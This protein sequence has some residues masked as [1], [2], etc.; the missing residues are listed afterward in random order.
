MLGFREIKHHFNKPTQTFGCELLEWGARR[1]VLK[2]VSDVAYRTDGLNVDFPVGTTTI[3][4]YWDDRGYVVWQMYHP[5]SHLLGYY[6]HMV[7]PVTIVRAAV[8]YRD[9]LID[10]WF[11]PDGSHRVLDEDELEQA[12]AEG[13]VSRELARR[14]HAQ[15]AEV[16][17]TWER[18]VERLPEYAPGPARPAQA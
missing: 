12:M 16:L 7:E 6:V 2:Y 1:V 11:W 15:K 4:S 10:I 3:A 17:M 14:I 13:K 9:A 5:D 18:I 8:E